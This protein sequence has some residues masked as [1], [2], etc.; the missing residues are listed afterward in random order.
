MNAGAEVTDTLRS[1]P[2]LLG[3]E[4]GPLQEEYAPVTAE[5]SHQMLG[6]FVS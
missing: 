5:P 3:I 6:I 2:W 4:L 1:L